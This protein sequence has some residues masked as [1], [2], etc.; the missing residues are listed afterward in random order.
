MPTHHPHPIEAR[1]PS[2]PATAARKAAAVVGTVFLL[3]GVLGFIPGIS[4]HYDRLASASHHSQA[5]L[6]G[7]FNVSVM[8]NLAHLAFGVIGIG[9]ARSITA[10]QFYLVGGGLAYVM[11]FT[12]G[13]VID[14]SSAADYM[15][16]NT[17]DS[18]LHLGLG[19]GTLALGIALR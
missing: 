17:A 3:L 12:Y 2:P 18:W 1:R 8:R 9:S 13:V 16:V 10:A 4:D 19:A 6:L 11:L 15:P 7:A 5:A 14:Y